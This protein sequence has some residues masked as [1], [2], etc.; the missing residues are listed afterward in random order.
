MSSSAAGVVIFL[1]MILNE[2]SVKLNTFC[3]SLVRLYTFRGRS[4]FMF[5]WLCT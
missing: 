4:V 2:S 3:P 5:H 1:H